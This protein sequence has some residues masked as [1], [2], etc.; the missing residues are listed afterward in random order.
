M[1]LYTLCLRIAA[2]VFV[3]VAALHLVLGPA[4]DVLL[5]ASLPPTARADPVLDSQNRFYGVTFALYGVLLWLAATN[6]DRYRPMLRCLLWVFFAGGLA[7][8]VSTVFVGYP[9]PW[10][11]ALAVT[12]LVLP[13]ILLAWMPATPGSNG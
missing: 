6:L 4:A 3:L 7:R 5:G 12:E 2:P 10:V 8:I 13:P 11:A 1:N 9:G